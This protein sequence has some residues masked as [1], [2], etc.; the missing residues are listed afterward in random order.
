MPWRLMLCVPMAVR[1]HVSQTVELFAFS[2][3]FFMS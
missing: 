2:P 1:H 3:A